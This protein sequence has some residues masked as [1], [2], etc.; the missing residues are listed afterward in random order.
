MA[1]VNLL[2]V[3]HFYQRHNTDHLAI[4]QQL[5][6]N[7]TPNTVAYV[8]PYYEVYSYR[9]YCQRFP[10]YQ[11]ICD[12]ISPENDIVV[13]LKDSQNPSSSQDTFL[14]IHRTITEQER[15]VIAQSGY[16]NPFDPFGQSVWRSALA[17]GE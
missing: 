13:R 4:L 10:Q 6:E 14:L 11:P 1:A 8:M 17:A 9:Y 2:G 16:H 3:H 12:D 15:M 7:W 5:S